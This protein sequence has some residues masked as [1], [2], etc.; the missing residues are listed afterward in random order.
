M[1]GSLTQTARRT[2]SPQITPL[3]LVRAEALL[4]DHGKKGGPKLTTGPK[5]GP[6][7]PAALIVPGLQPN[8][9]DDSFRDLSSRS[10][11]RRKSHTTWTGDDEDEDTLGLSAALHQEL[12]HLGP[13]SYDP[14]L[15]PRWNHLGP[16]PV[17]FTPVAQKEGPVGRWSW[18]QQDNPDNSSCATGHSG[19]RL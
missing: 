15:E 7:L 5:G 16:E 10:H 3:P 6:W 2:E 17:P 11:T 13:E 9:A 8:A 12:T 4:A 14:P 19:F 1:T 18:D